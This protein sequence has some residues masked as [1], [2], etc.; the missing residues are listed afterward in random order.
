MAGATRS[1]SS[2]GASPVSGVTSRAS[3]SAPVAALICDFC[4]AVRSILIG[5]LVGILTSFLKSS[6]A[7]RRQRQAEVG[8]AV[9]HHQPAAA[10]LVESLADL[11]DRLLQL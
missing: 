3:T 9:P 6:P 2:S 10:K 4:S 8:G 5:L 11:L 7:H 1:S